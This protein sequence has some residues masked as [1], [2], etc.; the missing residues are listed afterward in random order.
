MP[1]LP[2]EVELYRTPEVLEQL[3]EAK[4]AL[5]RLQ[6]R[7]IAIPNQGLLINTISLQEARASS[8]IE[9]IFTTDDEL[10]KALDVDVQQEQRMRLVNALNEAKN[11]QNYLL[12]LKNYQHPIKRKEIKF[13]VASKISRDLH[14]VIS[15]IRKKLNSHS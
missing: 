9:N 15:S 12:D 14:Q 2:I 4:A 11:T 3:G 5:G 8:A 1:S 10:Y 7:S 13:A 6:G